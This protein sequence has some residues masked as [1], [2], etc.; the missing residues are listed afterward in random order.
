MGFGLVDP[1]LPVISTQLNASASQVNLLFTSYNGVMAVASIIT[2]LLSKKLGI[3]KTLICGTILIAIFSTSC[4]L[5]TNVNGI[6]ILRCAWGLENALFIATALTAIINY[7]KNNAKRSIIL[8]EAAMGVGFSVGPLVGG[9]LGQYSWKFPF[10]AVG[11]M[12]VIAFV[13]ITVFI[14]SN[15]EKDKHF[16]DGDRRNISIL[17][18]FKAILKY[19][20]I[21][22]C[23]IIALLYNFGFFTLFAYSPY[24]MGLDAV[25][26]GLVFLCW[27][28]LVALMSTVVAPR[29]QYSY[30][31]IKPMYFVL[32]IFTFL[33]YLMAI[34]AE[35]S[36]MIIFAVILS[37]AVIGLNNTLMTTVVMEGSS[38]DRPTTSASYNFLRF[39]GS[40]IAPYLA[41]ILGENIS[42][43][44]PF[45]FAGSLLLISIIYMYFNR[46]NI[47][48]V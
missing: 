33:L 25:G 7:S 14:P 24:I 12:M 30:G 27:G 10:F 4:G 46:K 1:I 32:G 40:A 6:I 31:V 28:I 16:G 5:M 22:T 38:I 48:S 35:N 13:L 2:G 21:R 41:G 37:G 43:S 26:I 36:T 34:F 3:K 47:I 9:L 15:H 44:A 45:I 29:I 8:Y 19:R 17:D 20:H 11:C 39:I 42:D 23:G 18:P